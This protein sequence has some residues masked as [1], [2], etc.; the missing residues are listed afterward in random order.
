MNNEDKSRPFNFIAIGGSSNGSFLEG[1]GYTYMNSTWGKI[2]DILMDSKCMNP[3]IYVDELDKVSKTE[4]VKE[5][6][7]ILTH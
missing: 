3:I 2:V 1:H 5:I 7:G 4:Q 6:I